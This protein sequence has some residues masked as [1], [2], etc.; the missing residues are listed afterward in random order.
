[1]E[2]YYIT[3][4][5]S[6]FKIRCNELPKRRKIKSG[7]PLV[8]F[9]SKL[10]SFSFRFWDCKSDIDTYIICSFELCNLLNGKLHNYI[11]ESRSAKIVATKDLK[12]FIHFHIL[13]KKFEIV[14]GCDYEKRKEEI[15]QEIISL[16]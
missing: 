3:T 12:L 16:L 10:D 2:N 14:E 5:D 9:L 7:M 4:S 6:E 13:D 8:R 15:F 11:N 1:M